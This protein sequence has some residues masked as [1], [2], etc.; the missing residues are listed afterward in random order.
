MEYSERHR[1]LDPRPL[2][3]ELGFERSSNGVLHIA[4]RTDMQ[5]C[6]GEML[7][8]W[9]ASRPATREYCWWH[10]LD[11]VSSTW[12]EGTPGTIPGSIHQV[13]ERFTELP[14]QKLSIQFCEPSE[15]FEPEA[16]A[17]AKTAGH[18]SVVLCVRGGA[19]FTPHRTPDGKVMGTRLIHV[20]RDTPWGLVLRSHF[21][22][23]QDIA[24][25]GFMS[26]E[27]LTHIFPEPV[28]PNTL[29]HCYDEFKFLARI[30][31]G[32]WESEGCEAARIKR[33]W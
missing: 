29:Q 18:L 17:A 20:G 2:A 14:A 25:S 12:V 11:H 28:G 1:L 15:F 22:M 9:F 32:I 4:I 30:L 6:S 24:D 31:P 19:G 5:A 7:S 13:E 27:E 33:P 21:F 26:V 16:L 3:I 8:W 10:P 23:G